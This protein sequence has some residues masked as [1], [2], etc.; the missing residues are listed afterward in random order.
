MSATARYGDP[1]L[2]DGTALTE[3][4][5]PA[6]PLVALE[7]DDLCG[8]PAERVELTASRIRDSVAL[9]V[10]VLRRP[11]TERLEPALTATTMTLSELPAP[12]H[13]KSLV[14]VPDID[15]SLEILRTAV[16]R[17]P[18]A[19]LC[20]GQLL[21]R[22]AAQP[23]M[24]ALAAEAAVYSMLLGGTEFARWLGERG[25]LP[26]AVDTPD[27]L[28]RLHRTGQHLAIVLDHPRR[29]NALSVRLRE[30]LLAA[31]QVAAA[32]PTIT[33][34][35]LSG[36]GPV[37]C[38]GGDLAEFG[39]STD[40]VA[41]YLVRLERAPWRVFDRLA[42]RLVVHTHGACIGAGAELAAFAGTVTATARTYFRFP[43]VR[44]GLVPGAGG[45]VGVPRRIGRWRAAWLML[46]EQRLDARTALRW[47]L[48]DR[49]VDE[50]G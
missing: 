41:A 23:T 42:D 10:G 20:L 39:M 45:T 29:R 28:V 8:A 5:V 40:P 33:S 21:R 1:L 16:A 25:P 48:V 11:P 15:D 6:R 12:A 38:S 18:Q 2:D 34:I 44:M 49:I 19:A 30:E 35:E 24:P 26:Q 36:A 47:G 37:F 46:S 14:T 32:D 9:V 22:N 4:G 27:P 31:A 43:E 17:S 7:L 3:S 13:L 50:R